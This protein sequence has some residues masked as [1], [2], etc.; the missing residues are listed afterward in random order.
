MKG[1]ELPKVTYLVMA[2]L[3]LDPRLLAVSAVCFSHPWETGR[4]ETVMD[5]PRCRK[6]SVR[7]SKYTNNPDWSQGEGQN[8]ECVRDAR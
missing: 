6:S 8:L 1:S 4:R 5:K 3:G 2:E 7:I